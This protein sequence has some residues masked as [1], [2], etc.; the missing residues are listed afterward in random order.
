METNPQYPISNIKHP[1]TKDYLWPHLRDLP[2]FR[3]LLRAVEARFYE[4]IELL[5]PTLDLGCGDGHFATIAFDRQLEVGVDPW[6]GPLQEAASRRAYH[7]LAQSDGAA[8]PFPDG[9]FASA[10][11]NSVLEHI[12]YL[13][14]VLQE[15][16]RVLKPGAPF[17][18]CVPNHNFLPNLSFGRLLNR[19]HLRGLGD[20]YR[21]FFNRISRHHHCDSTEVWGER[22]LRAG[23]KVER[24]WHYFS[25]AALRTLELGHYF[26]LP[27]WISRLL[28]GRW[29]LAPYRWN[30]SLTRRLVQPYYDEPIAA[31]DG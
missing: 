8:L 3:A 15:T 12:P 11:S 7:G 31:D 16:A 20:A 6:W 13:D 27:S 18:F 29:I 5:A 10:V 17:I 25:P 2:Y 28:T 21:A 30:L 14:V 4:D 23:F 22:L 24:C 19:I 9:T 26:G 1:R